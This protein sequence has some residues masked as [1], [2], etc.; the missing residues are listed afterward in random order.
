MECLSHTLY[1]RSFQMN[2]LHYLYITIIKN[3]VRHSNMKN[4]C[5]PVSLPNTGYAE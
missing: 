2:T 3:Y 1:V 5:P 4:I